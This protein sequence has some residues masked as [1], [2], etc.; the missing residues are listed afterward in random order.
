MALEVA[1]DPASPLVKLIARCD[2]CGAV[3][4]VREY[5]AREYDPDD[6]ERQSYQDGMAMAAHLETC[7]ERN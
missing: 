3:V 6:V 2:L 4:S 1:T 5:D 7:R